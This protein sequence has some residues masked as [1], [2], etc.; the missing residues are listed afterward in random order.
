MGAANVES[1]VGGLCRFTATTNPDVR[2]GLIANANIVLDLTDAGIRRMQ[3][4]IEQRDLGP[5]LSRELTRPLPRIRS[6]R[7]GS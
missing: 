4:L 1:T 5:T 6:T 2:I 7:S 3:D